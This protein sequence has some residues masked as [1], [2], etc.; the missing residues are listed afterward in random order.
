MVAN[1]IYILPRLRSYPTKGAL[2]LVLLPQ[3]CFSK[4]KK[5]SCN[6]DRQIETGAQE[7]ISAMYNMIVE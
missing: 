7:H 3:V 4:S 2:A 6:A 1:V 5:A